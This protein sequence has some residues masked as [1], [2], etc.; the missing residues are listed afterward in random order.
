MPRVTGLRCAAPSSPTTITDLL[1][2][3]AVRIEEAGIFHACASVRPV[4]ETFTGVPTLS[5]PALLSIL[6]QTSTVVLP[7]S[8]AG[9]M[10]ATSR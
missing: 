6:S 1:P 4:M 8:S 9:L 10:S 7:G 3:C 2:S 5:V